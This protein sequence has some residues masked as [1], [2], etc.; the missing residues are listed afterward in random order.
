MFKF[1]KKMTIV[2]ILIL[3][4]VVGVG[5]FFAVV[6]YKMSLI[7]EMTFEDM[8]AYTTKDNENAIVTI[9]IIKD[10]E[11]NYTVYGENAS[12]LKNAEYEYEIG[13]ITK[14]FTSSLLCKAISENKVS[15]KDSIDKYLELP[16]KEY[17]PT[18]AR[19]VTHTSGYK[20]YYFDKQMINNFFH[21]EKNDFYGISN[22]AFSEKLAGITLE[23]REYIFN[24]SNF[25]ISVVGSVLSKIYGDNYPTIMDNYIKSEL[26]LE[27]TRIS[28]S[29]GNLSG[30]W[31]WK[32]DDAYVPA[33]GIISTIGDMMKYLELHMGEVLP[34]LSLGH[35]SITKVNTTT[36]QY[37]KMG[38]RMDEMGIGWMIDTEKNII[39]HNG[40]T[41]N[42][43]S[44]IA[45]DKKNQVGIIILSNLPPNYRIPAT[46]MGVK[47]MTTLQ[48]QQ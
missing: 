39:W 32:S 13:S 7:P 14:T 12:V 34:Y 48:N 40:A 3:F 18:L 38:I 25:G 35:E 17:Y 43:N 41:S 15:L 28:D 36:K 46:L 16:E 30:Y 5:V 19:L 45:F 47:L 37:E 2:L 8:L 1:K 31:N 29:K 27:H 24:Y 33:G 23:N 4:I 9:G 6:S 44:Y 20:G 22:K 21:G 10:G 11:T 26:K 42:F